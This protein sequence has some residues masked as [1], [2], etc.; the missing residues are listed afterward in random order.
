MLFV[1]FLLV[2]VENFCPLI[3]G[4]HK[5]FSRVVPDSGCPIFLRAINLALRS[6]VRL[7]QPLL[8]GLLLGHEFGIAAEQDV[9]STASHVGGDGDH[10]LASSL[11]YDFR[12]ALVEFGIEHDVLD[13]FFL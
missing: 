11:G 7:C 3:G 12:F 9:S 6:T 1:G 5:F 10:A 4:N 2:A 8:H 13:T